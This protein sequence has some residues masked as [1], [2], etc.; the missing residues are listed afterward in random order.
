MASDLRHEG[1]QCK[2]EWKMKK[3]LW[4]RLQLSQIK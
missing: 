4:L 1:M 3:S 2:F